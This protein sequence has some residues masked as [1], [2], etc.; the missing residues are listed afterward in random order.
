MDDK[1]CKKCSYYNMDF[2]KH[3]PNNCIKFDWCVFY[4]EFQRVCEIKFNIKK[5]IKTRKVRG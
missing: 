4:Q 1:Q 5:R 3:S 2:S